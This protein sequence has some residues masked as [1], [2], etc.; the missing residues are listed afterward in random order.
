[1]LTTRNSLKPLFIPRRWASIDYLVSS[2]PPLPQPEKI[3]KV[4]TDTQPKQSTPTANAWMKQLTSPAKLNDYFRLNDYERFTHPQITKS[5]TF[6]NKSKVELEWTLADY[7]E[8]PD[9]KYERLAKE[10]QQRYDDMDPFNKTE[11]DETHV[12]SKKSFGINPKHLRILPEIL[13]MGHTNTGKSSLVNS[14][15]VGNKR[16]VNKSAELAYVS[17][18]AGYTKTLNCFNIANALRFVDSP[19]YGKF[20]DDKQGKAVIDY[21]SQRNQLKKALVLIDSVAKVREEDTYIIEHLV[22]E[23]VPFDL[24]F[25]KVDE[26]IAQFIPR[27]TLKAGLEPDVESININI[28]DYYQD[29]LEESNIREM[30][31]SPRLFFTNAKVNKYVHETF[32]AKEIRC[33]ILENC[34]LL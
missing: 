27:K 28:I 4:H 12:N 19:G 1:M 11:Y 33:S 3:P 25:T 15:L 20:G 16:Q 23:G 5:Q 10:R 13:I 30:A 14:L 24:V 9:V 29:I 17:A 18:R 32:G 7:D 8:I 22:A 31:L 2:I 34:G 6:F 26:I 21:I